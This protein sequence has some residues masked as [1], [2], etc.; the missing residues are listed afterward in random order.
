MNQCVSI[1]T[2]K[3]GPFS[4]TKTVCYLSLGDILKSI[5]IV[6]YES[7]LSENVKLY[8][9]AFMV[10]IYAGIACTCLLDLLLLDKTQ[11]HA[12]LYYHTYFWTHK[13]HHKTDS[14]SF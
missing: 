12:C 8:N 5:I 13:V 1:I 10:I 4:S 2:Y 9:I 7:K 14:S 6:G 11:L 3:F